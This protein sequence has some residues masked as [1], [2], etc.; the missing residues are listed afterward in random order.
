[1]SSINVTDF[2]NNYFNQ[3][4][5]QN[6]TVTCVMSNGFE[7]MTFNGTHCFVPFVRITKD[8]ENN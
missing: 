3:N 5:I 2:I 8:K 7:Y 4:N 6:A 1:M